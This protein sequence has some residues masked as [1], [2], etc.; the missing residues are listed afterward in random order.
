MPK[1]TFVIGHE[2]KTE[3]F[4]IVLTGRALVMIAEK[5]EEIVAPCIFISKPGVRKVLYIAEDMRWATVH[6]TEE[7]DMEKLADLLIVKSEA[8]QY[9]H[10]QIEK[11]KEHLKL[12]EANAPAPHNPSDL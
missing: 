11:L 1:G 4:N 12:K 6:P 2:H 5:V 3:H 7:T 8:F 10:E 9:H